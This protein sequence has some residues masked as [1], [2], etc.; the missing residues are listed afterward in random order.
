MIDQRTNHELVVRYSSGHSTGGGMGDAHV[1]SGLLWET[2]ELLQVLAATIDPL[3][4]TI[5]A[6]DM[7]GS[8]SAELFYLK[9]AINR[10]AARLG[11]TAAASIAQPEGTQCRQVLD[12]MERERTAAAPQ[13][14]A[15][16]D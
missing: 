13:A 12:W 14:P 6:H 7:D 1:E 16:N 5:C 8:A 3:D 9:A 2:I 4:Y 15:T 11:A 10:I